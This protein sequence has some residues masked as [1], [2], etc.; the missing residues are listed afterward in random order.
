MAI[1]LVILD[2]DGTFTDATAEAEPF[3]AGF[4][5]DFFDLLGRDAS[6]AWSEEEAKIGANPSE[7][8]WRHSGVIT[9]PAV[10]DPY[11]HTSAVAQSVCDR[12]GILRDETTRSDVLQTLYRKNYALT[13]SVPRPDA[14]QVLE[15][16]LGRALPV[17]IV[18]NSRPDAVQ[19]KID[20][21]DIEGVQDLCVIGDAKKFVIDVASRDALFDGLSDLAVPGLDGREVLV[22]RGHYYDV[23]RQAWQHTGTSAAQTLVVG[24]IFEL[25]LALPLSLGAFVHLV[26]GEQTPSYEIDFVRQHP[27]GDASDSLAGMLTRL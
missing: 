4:R 5:R 11:L 16:L 21:I 22:K 9:A 18:T 27:R 26:Y 17:Y 8:G 7:Y 10:A 12:F 19:A 1:E 13:R 25:D 3:V 14:K 20:A 24:D 2:F 6:D 23:L 15:T